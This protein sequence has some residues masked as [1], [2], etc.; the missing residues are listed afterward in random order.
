MQ[1]ENA[2]VARICHDLITPFNAINI[3][4]EAFE[5]SQDAVMLESVK[6]STKRA[7]AILTF[8]R[9][10]FS[11]KSSDFTYTPAS[12]TKY[13]SEFLSKIEVQL[14]SDKSN[15]SV[16]VGQIV[17]YL[18]TVCKDV[19]PFGGKLSIQ[20]Y[21]SE[22]ICECSGQCLKTP[23]LSINADITYKN[24]FQYY[25]QTLL[26]KANYKPVISQDDDRLTIHL[27]VY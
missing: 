23:D 6:D 13:I 27:C 19:M 25:L 3:G 16:Q 2:L 15:I 9:E 4:I 21:D 22:I 8:I 7:N 10:L 24:I 14:K 18:A 20:I 1:F 26:S 11:V 17:L 5:M 12:L